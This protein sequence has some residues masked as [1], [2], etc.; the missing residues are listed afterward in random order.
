MA[1]QPLYSPGPSQEPFAVTPS[2][3]TNFG[4]ESRYLYVGT[5]GNVVIVTRGGQ[6]VTYTAVPAGAYVWASCIRV[7]STS[8]TA[9]NIVAHP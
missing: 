5:T 8:T 4:Q 6:T 3:S 7:N 2:D 1:K 9:S